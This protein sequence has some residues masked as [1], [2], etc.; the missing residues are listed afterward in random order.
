MLPARTQPPLTASSEA[1]GSAGNGGATQTQAQAQA[2][3]EDL[4]RQAASAVGE[5]ERGA[6]MLAKRSPPWHRLNGAG[7]ERKVTPSQP[8]SSVSD[9]PRPLG[10]D[11]DHTPLLLG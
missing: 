9:R 7:K 1:A 4:P 6:L 10:V 11:P 8:A 2:Q 3:H 5:P